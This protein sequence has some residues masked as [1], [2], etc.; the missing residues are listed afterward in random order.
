MSI[1]IVIIIRSNNMRMN[2]L[3]LCTTKVRSMATAV[4]LLISGRQ[5]YIKYDIMG[6][7]VTRVPSKGMNIL[8]NGF[9]LFRSGNYVKTNPI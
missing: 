4:R 6:V 7:F 5:S 2:W 8:A 3:R 1:V 9:S